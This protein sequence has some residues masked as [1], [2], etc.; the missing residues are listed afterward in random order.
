MLEQFMYEPL[1]ICARC[2]SCLLAIA[3]IAIAIAIVLNLL[4]PPVDKND[5]IVMQG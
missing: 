4:L 2:A 1:K 3:I 5:A